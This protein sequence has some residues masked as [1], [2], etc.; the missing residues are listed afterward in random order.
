MPSRHR[1]AVTAHVPGWIVPSAADNCYRRRAL[2]AEPLI[3]RGV[4]SRV[5][6]PEDRD[7]D[8]CRTTTPSAPTSEAPAYQ[9]S[10]INGAARGE[11]DG[12]L[13]AD[14]IFVAVDDCLPK[15]SRGSVR[16]DARSVR[17]RTALGQSRSPMNGSGELDLLALQGRSRPAFKRDKVVSLR[18]KPR[19]AIAWTAPLDPNATGPRNR[20]YAPSVRHGFEQM[21]SPVAISASVQ[22]TNHIS[23]LHYIHPMVSGR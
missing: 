19:S 16:T 13:V 6:E 18:W 2:L 22:T 5:G 11:I 14:H 15:R 1:R 20:R 7:P 21:L 4:A 17:E 9:S 10:P 8:N 12:S 23:E 3:C